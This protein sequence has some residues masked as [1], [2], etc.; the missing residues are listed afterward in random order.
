MNTVEPAIDEWAA[1]LSGARAGR[2]AVEPMRCAGWALASV[3]PAAGRVEGETW[4]MDCFD[5]SLRGWPCKCRVGRPL[6]LAKHGRKRQIGRAPLRQR[7]LL[8]ADL[9]IPRGQHEKT[10]EQGRAQ[11]ICQ[12]P[13]R[14]RVRSSRRY[15]ARAGRFFCSARRWMPRAGP[16]GGRNVC[17]ARATRKIIAAHRSLILPQA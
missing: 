1:S 12:A 3:T 11:L 13:A 16:L 5:S 9:Q 4:G 15:V 10:A 17:G 7:V 8:F 14:E 6:V 2:L